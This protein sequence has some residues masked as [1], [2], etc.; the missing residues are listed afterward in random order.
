L[1]A[2]RTGRVLLAG[3]GAF[4]ALTLVGMLAATTRQP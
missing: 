3:S 1:R 2:A 4:I